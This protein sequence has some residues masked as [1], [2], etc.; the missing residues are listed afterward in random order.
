L[1]KR[2]EGGNAAA[3]WKKKKKKKKKKEIKKK[4]KKKKNSWNRC[5]LSLEMKQGLSAS[6]AFWLGAFWLCARLSW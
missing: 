4:K 3:F 6:C 5:L 1:K 2:A